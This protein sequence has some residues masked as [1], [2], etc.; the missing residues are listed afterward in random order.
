MKDLNWL[1][2]VKRTYYV[3][4]A[5]AVVICLIATF[6]ELVTGGNVLDRGAALVFS[7]IVPLIALKAAQ[8]IFSGLQNKDY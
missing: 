8:W 5:V 3:L 6:G 2:A 7:L 4:W 1:L